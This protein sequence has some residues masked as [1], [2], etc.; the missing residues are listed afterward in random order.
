M[1]YLICTTNYS[2]CFKNIHIIWIMTLQIRYY[3]YTHLTS[4]ETEVHAD[5]LSNLPKSYSQ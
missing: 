5:N 2:E 1:L 3:Y 4:K